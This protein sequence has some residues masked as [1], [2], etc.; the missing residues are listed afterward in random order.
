VHASTRT[1]VLW[2]GG[3]TASAHAEELRRGHRGGELSS[4]ASPVLGWLHGGD[5]EVEGV[6]AGLCAVG[7][8]QRHNHSGSRAQRACGGG[9][10]A[11]V[12]RLGERGKGEGGKWR[13]AG[14]L[15]A[16]VATWRVRPGRGIDACWP[17]GAHLLSKV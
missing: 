16:R 10:G 7:I 5:G 15:Q 9:G 6:K 13:E 8:G 14:G 1:E 17:R 3:T 12:L 4:A 11:S 2:R